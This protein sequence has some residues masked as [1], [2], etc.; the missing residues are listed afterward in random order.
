MNRVAPDAKGRAQRPRRFGDKTGLPHGPVGLDE[1]VIADLPNGQRIQLMPVDPLCCR[2]GIIVVV[3][4]DVRV[5]LAH[6]GAEMYD[7]IQK[8]LVAPFEE[9]AKIRVREVDL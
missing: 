9:L 6:S 2:T 3:E 7:E 5:L 8:F 1:I 4:D